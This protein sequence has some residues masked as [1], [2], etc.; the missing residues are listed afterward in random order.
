MWVAGFSFNAHLSVAA[1]S[2]QSNA[3]AFPCQHA[4][5]APSET[6]QRTAESAG[7]L[8]ESPILPSDTPTP[9][10]KQ[11]TSGMPPLHSP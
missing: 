1:G 8:P 2:R 5:R 4:N 10:A 11:L 9:Y 6:S 7:R 3:R